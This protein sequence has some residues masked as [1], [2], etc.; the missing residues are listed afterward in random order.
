VEEVS[1]SAQ[2]LQEMAHLLQRVVGQFK[3]EQ[4]LSVTPVVPPREPDGPDRLAAPS[5]AR[6]PE[7]ALVRANG[8]H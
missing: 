1:A 7:P 3:L 5:K 2:S 4:T 6:S 8:W